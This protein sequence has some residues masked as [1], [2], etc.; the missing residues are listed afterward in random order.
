M[1]ELNK[2]L[3][4]ALQTKNQDYVSP[5]GIIS[6]FKAF[7]KLSSKDSATSKVLMYL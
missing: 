7:E 3:N 4:D 5:N 6:C 2:L 1:E